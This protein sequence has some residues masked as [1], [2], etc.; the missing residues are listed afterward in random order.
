LFTDTAGERV[1]PMPGD[2]VRVVPVGAPASEV[3]ELTV[4][5]LTAAGDPDADTVSGDVTPGG[6]L[7]VRVRDAIQR[8]AGGG[9]GP[10]GGGNQ[11]RMEQPEIGADGSW[12]FDFRPDFDVLPG[13][14]MFA[15]YRVPSGHLVQRTRYVPLVNAQI[16]GA[17]V[18]G[19]TEPRQTVQSTLR[20]DASSTLATG[21]SQAGYGSRYGFELLDAASKAVMTEG[22]QTVTTRLAGEDVALELP[23]LTITINWDNLLAE[24]EGG[25]P[26]TM[27]NIYRPAGACLVTQNRQVQP[28]RFNQ[29]GV[30]RTRAFGMDPGE[31]FEV[32]LFTED[33]HRMYRHVYRTLGQVYVDTDRVSGIATPGQ[34]V[35][36]TL[37]DGAG[38]ERAAAVTVA[39]SDGRFTVRFTGAAGAELASRPGDVVRLE[40]SGETPEIAVEPL[41]VDW[42]EGSPVFGMASP[43][44]AV[45]LQ[46]ALEDLPD[47]T[48]TMVSDQD[49][50]FGFGPDDVPP[51][52]AWSMADVMGARA[53]I[54]TDNGHQIVAQVGEEPDVPLP[55][56]IGGDRTVFL[57]IAFNRR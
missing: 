17:N 35:T 50:A 42:S 7:Q 53:V 11:V 19:F 10:G 16:G 1:L 55:P 47:I 34:E 25:A 51:R 36:V 45:T 54:E 21:S 38:A 15:L 31:G 44:R 48:V 26:G 14:E 3:L 46:L 32:A 30:A 39:D 29:E 24:I 23:E 57:P 9:P 8:S 41:S 4:P 13:T 49:G 37:L 40:G 20:D 43:G 28:G 22:G 27:V 12:S 56:V 52:A 33:G 6:I 2:I 5:I 18:C